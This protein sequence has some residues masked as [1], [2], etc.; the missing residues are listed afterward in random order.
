MGNAGSPEELREPVPH[1]E[2]SPGRDQRSGE[3]TSQD[4]G[5]VSRVKTITRIPNQRNSFRAF[6]FLKLY[7]H[8]LMIKGVYVH[9]RK[10]GKNRD[11]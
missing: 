7:S 10:L 4:W 5:S 1:L 9:R 8:L 2:G 6:L 11:A 3:R